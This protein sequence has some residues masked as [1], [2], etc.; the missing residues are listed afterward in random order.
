[1]P[2]PGLIRPPEMNPVYTQPYKRYLPGA[3]DDSLSILEKMNKVIY[4]LNQL[5]EITNEMLEK[6]NDV[7][8]WVMG[9]GLENAVGNK[10]DEWLADGTM[11]KIINQRILGDIKKAI[12]ELQRDKVDRKELPYV[13]IIDYGGDPTGQRGSS[14][15]LQDALEVGKRVIIPAGTFLIN[16]SIRIPSNR[17]IEL[18]RFA[19]LKRSTNINSMFLNDSNG[20]RGGYSANTNIHISGGTIDLNGDELPS[21]CTAIGFGH[22]S[23]ISVKNVRFRGLYSW[24]YIEYNGVSE[25]VI[26]DCN[27]DGCI[28]PDGT[29]Q[30]QLDLMRDT[31]VFPWFGPYDDTPCRNIL[32]QGNTFKNGRKG[33]G[34]HS[35]VAGVTHDFIKIIN[36]HFDN[37]SNDAID[38]QNYARLIIKGNTLFNCANGI[39]VRSS[40]KDHPIYGVTIEGNTINDCDR[41]E[42]SRGIHIWSTVNRGSI[43]N[44]VINKVGRHGIGVDYG[45][46][47]SISNNVVTNCSQAGVYIYG[48]SH[49]T[50]NGNNLSVNNTSNTDDRFDMT[51]GYMAT[52]TTVNMVVTG[53]YM[54]SIGLR[55][56]DKAFITNNTI[57]SEA[58][59]NLSENNNNRLIVKDNFVGA[60]Y[61]P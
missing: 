28:D 44:N 22:C 16:Q 29:E 27:F 24:H 19:T 4:Y 9:N 7:Y 54:E 33:L 23:N 2:K 41:T 50:L 30:V 10:L 59:S 37:L 12:E 6:W 8:E 56:T 31:G 26:Q 39:M 46:W 58:K 21:R 1:M 45:N 34:S 61:R 18:E 25:G 40:G 14:K 55:Y 48:S 32:I 15:A 51:I 47:W 42:N 43:V 38:C 53:N 13:N 60:S 52:D 35:M 36:N 5:G 17:S 57:I 49:V 3:F 20:T 11:D